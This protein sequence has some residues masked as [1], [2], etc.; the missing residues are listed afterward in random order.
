MI[1]G[2]VSLIQDEYIGAAYHGT[3]CDIQQSQNTQTANHSEY[4]EMSFRF[5]PCDTKNKGDPKG[6]YG[7]EINSVQGMAEERS[8]SKLHSL[9]LFH[10]SW[11]TAIVLLHDRKGT[12]KRCCKIARVRLLEPSNRRFSLHTKYVLIFLDHS[13]LYAFISV[14]STILSCIEE[15]AR[16]DNPCRDLQSKDNEKCKDCIIDVGLPPFVRPGVEPF[17]LT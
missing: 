7:E 15:E 11:Q 3:A 12:S 16:N 6:D 9:K 13:T 5:N 2:K 10:G 8:P 4:V 14:Y 17:V 1:W